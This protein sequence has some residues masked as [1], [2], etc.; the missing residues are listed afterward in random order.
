MG[1]PDELPR[2]SVKSKRHPPWLR[3]AAGCWADWLANRLAGRLAGSRSGWR[4]HWLECWQADWLV[5]QPI[6]LM[7]LFSWK[8]GE[9]EMRKRQ[10]RE[11]D[12]EGER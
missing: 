4:P 3:R 11:R 5:A 8:C 1:A 7:L 2:D 6:L 12:E 10:I 9:G